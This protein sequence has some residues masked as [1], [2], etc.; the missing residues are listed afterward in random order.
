M[1]KARAFSELEYS[2]WGTAI[3]GPAVDDRG[4]EAVAFVKANSEKSIEMHYDESTFEMEIDGVRIN[5]EDTADSLGAAAGGTVILESTTLGFVETFMCCR[6]LRNAGLRTISVLYVE[7][8]T[9]SAPRRSQVL[10]KRDFDLS[11]AVPGYRP[12]PG[13]TF[14]LSTLKPQ[15]AVFFLGYEDHRFDVALE[16]LQQTVQPQDCSVVL[17]V[18]A[19][20]PGWEMNSFANNVHVIRDKDLSGGIHFCGAENPAAAVDI[21]M[22][23]RRSLSPNARMFLV[24]IG[25]KP[26]GI[27]AA[28]FAAEHEDVGL[29][30]DHPKRRAGRS[31]QSSSWH[32]YETQ[33]SVST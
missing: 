4:Q 22:E 2:K 11:E 13:A 15:H 23:I 7:P 12:I 26:M 27:A 17:G 1:Q 6:S 9:Y 16:E 33:F 28:I 21:L 24:P 32:L 8:L 31:S 29:L 3:V 14:H 30:Y 25:T 10:H 5:S 20:Q 19:Y 18:P